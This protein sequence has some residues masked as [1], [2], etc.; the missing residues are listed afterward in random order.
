MKNIFMEILYLSKDK[1]LVH[2]AVFWVKWILI[3]MF[4]LFF[5]GTEKKEDDK[6]NKI[7]LEFQWQLHIAIILYLL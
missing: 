5:C 1:K 4:H 3:S 2:E 7:L 6:L